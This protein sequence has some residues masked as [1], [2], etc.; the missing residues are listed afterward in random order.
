MNVNLKSLISKLNDTCRAALESAAGLCLSRTHY[1]VDLEHFC[2]K[3]IEREDSDFVRLL[4]HYD[5]DLTRLNR[6]LTQTL[7]GFK[8]GNQR[9][10]A[11]SPRIPRLISEAW[12][13]TSIDFNESS[14]RSAHILLALLG[15]EDSAKYLREESKE[16]IK[17]SVEECRRDLAMLLAE[18]PE[19][20][21]KVSNSTSPV[22]SS[23]ES[24]HKG[25]PP[26]IFISYRRDDAGGWAGRLYDKLVQQFGEDH[27]FMDID[28]ISPGVDFVE[29]IQQAV[30]SC[31][32][33]LA[34]IGQRWLTA[35]DAGTS[36]RRIDIP[37]D[38]VRVEIAAALKRNIRVI[39]VLLPKT[40]MPRLNDLPQVLRPLSRRNAFDLGETRFHHDVDRLLGLLKT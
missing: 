39:P 25:K 12:S 30:T 32:V 35:I 8:T 21:P 36:R 27:I 13:I 19:G 17:V 2:V 40:S 4:R 6:D 22:V 3:L 7:D 29:A 23:D 18:A 15:D 5:V 16:W 31:D 1:D 37:T 34:L 38:Y 14:I 11:L 20:V 28:T 26:N 24:I 9:T 33:L 10:P